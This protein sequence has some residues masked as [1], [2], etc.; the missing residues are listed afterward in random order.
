MTARCH[1]VNDHSSLSTGQR[2]SQIP[3]IVSLCPGPI[4]LGTDDPPLEPGAIGFFEYSSNKSGTHPVLFAYVGFE[5]AHFDK[6]W[7][8]VDN[9]TYSTCTIYLELAPVPYVGEER[10][11]KIENNRARLFVMSAGIHFTYDRSRKHLAG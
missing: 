3:I 7:A 11:W 2:I 1:V 10:L 5:L 6:I 9:D 8:Q 4:T